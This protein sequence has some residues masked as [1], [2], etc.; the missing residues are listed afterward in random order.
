MRQARLCREARAGLKD[1]EKIVRGNRSPA[2]NERLFKRRLTDEAARRCP[3]RGFSGDAGR[4]RLV[5][6]FKEEFKYY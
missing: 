5:T 1:L 4:A 6:K 2:I 3:A